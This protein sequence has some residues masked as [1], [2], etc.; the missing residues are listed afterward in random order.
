MTVRSFDVSTGA[1]EY[2]I[3]E[4]QSATVGERALQPGRAVAGN[5]GTQ[6]STAL[7]GLDELVAVGESRLHAT[8]RTLTAEER[9]RYLG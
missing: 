7:D 3:E 8:G 5:R 2:R 4:A 1:E 6:V 9:D